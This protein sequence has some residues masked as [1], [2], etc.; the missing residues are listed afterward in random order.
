M[1][2]ITKLIDRLEDYKESINTY[3]EAATIEA[4]DTIIDMNIGQMYDSGEDRTGKKITPEYAPE[5]V[6]IKREKGQPTNRVTLRDTFDFQK[7]IWVQYYPDSFEIKA[8]DWKTERLT[9]KYGDE[10][11][12]L[13]DE[14]VKYLCQNF[15]LPRLIKELKIKLGYE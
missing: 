14:M 9:Q 1:E 15:Y 2:K 6:R 8:S 3:L 11:L 5:T 10:I 7:S 12:G 13:Q 4:E